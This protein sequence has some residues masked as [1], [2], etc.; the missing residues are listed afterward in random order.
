[1]TDEEVS[2]LLGVDVKSEVMV[3][4][5]SVDVGVRLDDS[6]GRVGVGVRLGT[7]PSMTGPDGQPP[8]STPS[9]LIHGTTNGGNVGQLYLIPSLH[10]KSSGG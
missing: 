4:F 2:D 3:D 7:G 1:V 6:T 8:T 5:N 9:I 10:T